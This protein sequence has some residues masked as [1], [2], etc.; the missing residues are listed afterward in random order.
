MP[1]VIRILVYEGDE[2]KIRDT[3]LRNSVQR[4]LV[5]PR[6][7]ITEAVIGFDYPTVTSTEEEDK[8]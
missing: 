2:Q 5:L 3:M 4:I 8:E 6:M 7:T 1:R